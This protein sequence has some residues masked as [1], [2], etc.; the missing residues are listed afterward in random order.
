MHSHLFRADSGFYDKAIVSA[1]K[2]KHIS[3]TIRAKMTQGLQQAIV[4]RCRWQL[5][6]HDIEISE[7]YYQPTNW[8]NPKRMVVVRQ[9][10][11]RKANVPGKS[12]S[13]FK[14]DEDLIG[15]RYG[16]MITDLSLPAIEIWRLYRGSADCENRIKELKYDF[17]PRQLCDEGLL[18]YRGSTQCG[19]VGLQ[20]DEGD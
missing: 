11:T 10:I 5:V 17:E 2:E 4:Y 20:L 3:Y 8:D 15:W 1:L 12:L 9:H 13:L 7:F 6:E 18:G 14:D 19:H 16:A